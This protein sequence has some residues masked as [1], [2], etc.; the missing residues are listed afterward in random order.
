MDIIAIVP[1]KWVSIA[2]NTVIAPDID[3]A[4]GAIE[5]RYIAH[6]ENNQ[7]AVVLSGN[8]IDTSGLQTFQTREAAIAALQ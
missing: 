8:S 5:A 4:P 7:M 2:G 1:I 6:N 3:A